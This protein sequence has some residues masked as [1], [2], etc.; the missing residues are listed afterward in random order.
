MGYDVTKAYLSTFQRFCLTTLNGL[1]L[2]I[3][4]VSLST[5]KQWLSAKGQLVPKL[6]TLIPFLDLS[7]NQEYL[8]QRIRG[9]VLF[10][11][12]HC[13]FVYWIDQI[14]RMLFVTRIEV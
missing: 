9:I 6:S 12:L 10:L 13:I 4:E 7:A 1:I 8:V 3:T 5:L 2:L 14:G 11:F